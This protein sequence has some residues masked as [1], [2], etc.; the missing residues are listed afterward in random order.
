MDELTRAKSNLSMHA[1]VANVGL[2]HTV[3]DIVV[4]NAAIVDRI[5]L[6]LQQVFGEGRGLKTKPSR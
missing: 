6:L 2:T 3:E 5:N 4:A 1:Q